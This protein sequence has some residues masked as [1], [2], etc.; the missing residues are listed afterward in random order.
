VRLVRRLE[1]LTGSLIVAG[2]VAG[3]AAIFAGPVLSGALFL[4]L[5]P[6]F[7]A[8]GDNDVASRAP[9]HKGHVD[10]STGLYIREDDDLIVPD[11]PA[12]R[13]RRTYLSGDRIS[14]QFGA[15][16]THEGEWYLIGDAD[17]FQWAALILADGGRIRFERV[18]PGS[19]LLNAMFRHRATPTEF[20]GSELGWVGFEW[21][22]RF[23]DGRL[24]LFQ[25]C[26]PG[27]GT[28]CSLIEVRSPNGHR[29]RYE[30]DRSGKLMAMRGAT[31]SISFEYDDRNRIVRATDTR[32]S[33]RYAYDDAGRLTS[34]TTSDGVT[35]SYSY[36]PR[37]E[38]L[39]ID[40]PGWL[41]ENT[42]DDAGRCIRQLT[43]LP[44]RDGPWVFEFAYT[45]VD[46]SVS[47]TDVTENGTRTRYRFSPSHY[48]LSAIYDADGPSP[49][50]VTFDRSDSTNVALSMTVRCTGSDGHVVRTMPTVPG[51]EDEV[52]EDAVRRECK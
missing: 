28:T 36:S 41:I 27:P 30:R 21:A 42:F 46:G 19:S 29:V 24:A 20:F 22:L 16:T 14:R 2:F 10:I 25:G 48:M 7:A 34:V 9:V 39:T 47:E 12:F 37:D 32:D 35:R 6:S 4:L 50:T 43:H 15:G 18:S 31:G 26:G 1:I 45:V 5:Q 13:L 33:V 23:R 17:R 51:F 8:T 40:E 11:T 44:K 52:A 38:M 49:A 3:F